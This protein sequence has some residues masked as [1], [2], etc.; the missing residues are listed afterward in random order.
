MSP[1]VT[2]IKTFE[3][4]LAPPMAHKE[5]RLQRTEATHRRALRDA[6]DTGCTTRTAINNVATDYDLSSCAKDALKQ[7]VP[8]LR[9]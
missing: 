1:T 6:F 2:A 4:T 7:Y 3:A 8:R 5:R 9:R